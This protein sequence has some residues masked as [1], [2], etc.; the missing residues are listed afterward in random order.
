MCVSKQGSR[1][2][3]Q[4]SLWAIKPPLGLL[5]A[6]PGENSRG[7]LRSGWDV[8]DGTVAASAVAT[9]PVAVPGS[10]SSTGLLPQEWLT[11][12]YFP[13]VCFHESKV[14]L[15]LASVSLPHMPGAP[16]QLGIL[17][18]CCMGAIGHPWEHGAPA[19]TRFAWRNTRAVG[20]TPAWLQTGRRISAPDTK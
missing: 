2:Q 13:L 4:Q 1:T 6:A 11:G 3:L 18:G 17:R 20:P 12:W 14:G 5:W 19:T 16:W 8:R 9:P 7:R 10:T 15:R